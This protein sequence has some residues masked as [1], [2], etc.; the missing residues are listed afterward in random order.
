MN[1]MMIGTVGLVLFAASP[2]FASSFTDS[3]S[4]PEV[5]TYEGIPYVS[6]GIGLEERASLGAMSK[7]DNLK[8]SFALQ[9]KDYLGGAEVLIKDRSGKEIL[10]AVSEG[11]LFFAKL[12]EGIYT[13]EATAMGKTLERVVHV[14]SK[15][16]AQLYFA[17]KG[18]KEEVL[19]HT[20]AK[21]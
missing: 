19:H 4:Q 11:P 21:K 5:K 8:L 3:D 14:P 16:Q 6:G 9:N 2:I 10:E 15:G 18:S 1:K 12:P 17:W 20:L 13:V 7:T